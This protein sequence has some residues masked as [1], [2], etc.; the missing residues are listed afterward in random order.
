[1]KPKNQVGR[2]WLER[3]KEDFDLGKNLNE[4]PF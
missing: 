2:Q 3:D 4:Q 1:M